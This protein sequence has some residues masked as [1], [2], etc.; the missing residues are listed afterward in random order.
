MVSSSDTRAPILRRPRNFQWYWNSTTDPSS[1]I[2]DEWQKYTD[3][4]NHIIEDAFNDHKTSVEIDRDI[5]LDLK[6]Q[7]QYKKNDQNR[8]HP[9][10]RVHLDIDRK[11]VHFREERFTSP[12]TLAPTSSV[13]SQETFLNDDAS[14][15]LRAGHFPRAYYKQELEEENKTM[16][17]IVEEAAQGII[18]EGTA[19]RK[20]HEAQFIGE[21]LLE[22]KYYGNN[23]KVEAMTKI[24]SQIGETCINLYTRDSFL[25]KLINCVLRQPAT[26]TH[27]QLKTLGPF[28]YLLHNYLNQNYGNDVLTLYRG[29]TLTDEERQEF[30]K[31]KIRF[32]TFI[33]TSR[34]REVAEI[35]IGNTLLIFDLD[36]NYEDGVQGHCG[37]GISHLS[38]FPEE[39][40]FVICPM[41][42]FHFVNYH[43]DSETKKHFIYFKS[44][45]CNFILE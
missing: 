7:V 22:V 39:E 30:L 1:S 18:K 43:Y 33:S 5:I 13:P 15:W 29:L 45:E 11:N 16:N 17:G 10:R 44:A 34:K 42:D 20:Q 38:Q 28:C 37:A 4:E 40:E 23:E 36:G 8:L 14:F 3:I 32:T 31:K 41:T 12:I 21:R 27:E 25:Y 35:F 6:S 9:I 2:T 26:I 19:L 24:P